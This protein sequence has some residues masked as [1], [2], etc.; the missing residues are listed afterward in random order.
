MRN[1]KVLIVLAIFGSAL[2]S[3]HATNII[4]LNVQT[5]TEVKKSDIK[6]PPHG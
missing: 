4:D 5:T 1:K 3:A 6:V 2:F